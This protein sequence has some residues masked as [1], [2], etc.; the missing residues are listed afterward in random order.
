[1]AVT[2]TI[3]NSYKNDLQKGTIDVTSDTLKVAL[4]TSSYTFS[5]SHDFFN[6]ITN[7]ITGTGYTAGGATISNPTVSSGTFD[8][9]DT[10]WTNATFTARG[11][12]LYKD[13]GTASTSPLISFIDFGADNS[14]SAQTFTITWNA[15]GITTITA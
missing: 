6:D 8:A 4:V 3:Y 15:S 7:E 12:V 9:D 2:H 10:S 11:A 14:P 13:T 1:M 5:S